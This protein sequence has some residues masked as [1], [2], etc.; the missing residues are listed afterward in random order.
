[1]KYVIY[2]I[3]APFILK[4]T[5]SDGY[6]LREVEQFALR[7]IEGDFEILQSEHTTF[8]KAEQEILIKASTN[9][10]EFK[11]LKLTILPIFEFDWKG[12]LKE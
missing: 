4:E 9:P 11:H 5:E 6:H 8:L 1:M 3:T 2:Q 7:K 10:K 12:N